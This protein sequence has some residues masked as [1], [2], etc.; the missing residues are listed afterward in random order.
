MPVA[1]GG[2]SQSG[3]SAD[4]K[5][6]WYEIEYVYTTTNPWAKGAKRY[7]KLRILVDGLSESRARCYN[8]VTPGRSGTFQKPDKGYPFKR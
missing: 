5:S 3:W 2:G 1:A 4:V 7:Q 6:S 8:D